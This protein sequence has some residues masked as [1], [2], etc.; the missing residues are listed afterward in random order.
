MRIR[1]V[2]SENDLKQFIELPYRLYQDDPIWVPPL[3][4]EQAGQF[5]PKRNPMLARCDCSLLLLED[6]RRAIGRIS[7]FTDPVALDHWK[8]SIGLFGSYECAG[9]AAAGAMLLG[10]ARD[11]LKSRGMTWMRGPWS[12]ASQEWGLVVEGFQPAPVV[13]APYNPPAYNDHLVAF[14]LNKAKDLLAYYIDQREGYAIPARYLQ[15]TDAVRQRYGVSVRHVDMKRLED[16]VEVIVEVAN[17]S[18]AD[19]WGYYP[20][21]QAEGRAM[22]RDLKQVIS[23]RD[24][25]IAQDGEGRAV[26]FAM[27]IP[28]INTLLRGLNG[29]LLPFGWLKL[30]VGLRR[31]R[32][33]RLWAIGVV[34]E[35]QGKAV[36]AL[37]YRALY[38]ALSPEVDRVEVNYVL[39]DNV[40]MNNALRALGVKPLRRYRVYEM[41]I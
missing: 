35:Y 16:E 2:K 37:L 15:L 36:D 33:V 9:D 13:M 32:Q 34:P 6:D 40:R 31:I 25:V 29:R 22:A 14:G 4:S 10:A 18:L 7:A 41:E 8:Q 12:F 20:V 19:N 11:W 38:E 26:G 17:A 30:L 24:V 5:D 27:A 1:T 3:R 23:A 39:E 28:D 21:S